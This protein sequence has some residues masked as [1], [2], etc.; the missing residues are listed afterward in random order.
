MFPSFFAGTRIFANVSAAPTLKD[1]L[2][3]LNARRAMVVT[4]QGVVKAEVLSALMAGFPEGCVVRTFAD[5]MQDPTV[6]VMNK[7]GELCRRDAIDTIVGVGGGACLDAAKGGAITATT[8][9]SILEAVGEDKLRVQPLPVIAIPTTAGTG[10]EVSWHISVNDTERH[11]KVTVRS[12]RTVPSAA[13]LDPSLVATVPRPVAAA[14]GI[15][16]LTH[17]IESYVGNVGNWELTDAIALHACGMIGG[18][19]VAYWNNPRDR[20]HAAQMLM[21]SCFGGLAL[22]HSRTGIVHQMARPLGAQFHV[23]HGL[24]NAVLLP[25]C[26][27]FTY[28]SRPERFARIAAALGE[29]VSGKQTLSAAAAVVAAVRSINNAIG[30]PTSLAA[31]GVTEDAIEQLASDALQAKPEIRNPCLA[32]KHDVIQIYRQALR[33]DMP[34]EASA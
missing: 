31:F 32:A 24:A 12:P 27:Q 8:G 34:A 28:R 1:E 9:A 14:A 33:S 17:C 26:L 10:S 30:I 7:I 13:I 23:P 2:G 16:A 21:A 11:L 20:H 15:D 4:D 18:S 19:L 29:N 22:S 25:W 6:T 5:V 3:R